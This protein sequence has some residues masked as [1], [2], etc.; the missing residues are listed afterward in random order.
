MLDQVISG[1]ASS[2][3]LWRKINSQEY[4]L[5]EAHIF[6]WKAVSKDVDSGGESD[7]NTVH[8]TELVS[9][10]LVL[11]DRLTSLLKL[12]KIIQDIG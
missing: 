7:L 3:L 2:D 9:S 6:M 11:K 1:K 10:V 8:V 4:I 5:L 12:F